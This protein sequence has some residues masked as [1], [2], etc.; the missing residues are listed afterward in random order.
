MEELTPEEKV[1]MIAVIDFR[2]EKLGDY[3]FSQSGFTGDKEKVE[4]AQRFT[5]K[6]KI[7]KEKLKEGE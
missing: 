6:I 2:I 4:W 3:I 5:N 7:I 1:M